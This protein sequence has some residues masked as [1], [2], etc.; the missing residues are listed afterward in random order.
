MNL[1]ET[2]WRTY[3]LPSAWEVIPCAVV[4][5][6]LLSV[7]GQAGPAKVH[8]SLG[9]ETPFVSGGQ[10]G[11]AFYPIDIG[12]D[13]ITDF[14]FAGS[15]LLQGTIPLEQTGSV[16]P[17]HLLVSDGAGNWRH[18]QTFQFENRFDSH[19]ISDLDG[20][21]LGDLL[22]LE[23]IDDE[24]RLTL[25]LQTEDRGLSRVAEII[26]PDAEYF[27]AGP[28]ITATEGLV[29][30]VWR[31]YD[32]ATD[33]Y[34]R[35]AILL[36][37]QFESGFR[38]LWREP[39]TDELEDVRDILCMFNTASG[40][41][42]IVRKD[43]S[44]TGHFIASIPLRE[45]GFGTP[46]DLPLTDARWDD[47]HPLVRNGRNELWHWA[48]RNYPDTLS[49]LSVENDSLVSRKIA[50]TGLP[51][52][53][54]PD[55]SSWH[56]QT[57]GSAVHICCRFRPRPQPTQA[58][59]LSYYPENET[60]NVRASWKWP[61]DTY[62]GMA[63]SSEG[64]IEILWS[65]MQTSFLAPPEER[66][67]PEPDLPMYIDSL[68]GSADF[69]GDGLIDIIVD[70]F[71]QGEVQALYLLMGVPHPPW[72][73]EPFAIGSTTNSYF[74]VSLGDLDGDG[75]IDLLRSRSTNR[76]DGMLGEYIPFFW[77]GWRLTRG[78]KVE[79]LTEYSNKTTSLE[80]TG[81][82]LHDYDGDGVVELFSS[83]HGFIGWNRD[84][85][86]LQAVPFTGGIPGRE[87]DA[88]ADLDGDGRDELVSTR[89]RLVYIS[90]L[91]PKD[92][93]RER[94][95]TWNCTFTPLTIDALNLDDDPECEL[96]IAGRGMAS[97]WDFPDGVDSL[98]EV[99]KGP[100][101]YV[102][103]GR[104]TIGDIDLDGCTDLMQ[105][106]GGLIEIVWDAMGDA[107]PQHFIT[108]EEVTDVRFHYSNSLQWIDLDRD[109]DLDLMVIAQDGLR[110]HIND[111]IKGTIA[112]RDKP[113]VRLTSANPTRGEVRAA[114]RLDQTGPAYMGLYDVSG[115]R[116]WS[117]TRSAET[118]RWFE[119][120]IDP[121]SAG[122][123]LTSGV[124]FL[125][126]KGGGNEA[127]RR[128]VLA[129]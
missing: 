127:V 15:G 123:R 100:I 94:A 71:R 87:I 126:V 13:G 4:L 55:L 36:E 3:A 26:I 8:S 106:L 86:P 81:H 82:V 90:N 104:E 45:D 68:V 119:V 22:V 72:F 76:P 46:T 17:L 77:N 19:E 85:Q 41:I 108:V 25:L 38:V 129:R 95:G 14:A 29:V 102:E 32:E 117:S 9:L 43:V 56:A 97:I 79:V 75:S 105:S 118:G 52:S 113:W 63:V 34:I 60:A 37:W 115:R 84:R 93:T 35:G 20:D 112:E 98:P 89:S 28:E 67:A 116:I 21:G 12:A 2:N 27:W 5:M 122:R 110:F 111:L 53:E 42:A 11:T 40:V 120:V 73:S 96:L 48:D 114:I 58:V 31:W 124:Y 121:D 62:H 65:D 66:E 101:N 30:L 49:V 16:M 23:E 128:I 88:I 125:R 80:V 47:M 1:I 64:K 33:T 44:D 39:F 70:G 69:N 109:G 83:R 54:N 24:W 99:R 51:E 59:L 91:N 103:Y 78:E 50:I 57:S 10:R 7:A 61:D 74:G 18:T 6:I 107:V 92:G